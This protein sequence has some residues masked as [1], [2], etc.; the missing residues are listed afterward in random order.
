MATVRHIGLCGYALQRTRWRVKTRF[1][2]AP[3]RTL[4]R[5]FIT[6]ILCALCSC[7]DRAKNRAKNG[8]VPKPMRTEL[9][10]KKLESGSP[11][12]IRAFKEERELELFIGNKTTG[13]FEL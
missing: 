9:T 3:P 6:I 2:P 13:K 8:D 1:E 10:E 5:F 4:K 11:V 12:F 7:G